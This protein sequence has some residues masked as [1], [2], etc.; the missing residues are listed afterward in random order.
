MF[1]LVLK[2]VKYELVVIK[3]VDWCK[4]GAFYC[5]GVYT[6]PKWHANVATAHMS[7]CRNIFFQ[8]TRFSHAEEA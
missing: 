2:L 7:V 8:I 4:Y 5:I 3:L 6:M 1:T